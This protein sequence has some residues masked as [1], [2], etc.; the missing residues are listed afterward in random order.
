MNSSRFALTVISCA[1]SL[2]ASG[3]GGGGSDQAGSVT[4]LSVQPADISVTGSA[5]KVCGAGSAR[6]FVYGGTAPYRL[7]NP[8]PSHL[9]LDR[10][11]VDSRGDFFTVTFL[12]G[13]IDPGEIIVVDAND[14]QV[15]LTVH[16]V[17]GS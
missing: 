17:E 11:R 1:F 2:L 15:I 6:V 7:D 4:A 10:A 9:S 16:S 12:G 8:F 5:P 13:C 3:C 14:R